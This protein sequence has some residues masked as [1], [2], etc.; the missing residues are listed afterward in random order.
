MFTMAVMLTGRL[1]AESLRVGADLEVADLRVV[2]IGRHDVSN[3]TIPSAGSDPADDSPQGAVAG[4]PP[5]WT[6]LDFEA[7]DDRADDLAQALAAALETENGWWADFVVGGDHVVVFAGRVFRYRIG[8]TRARAEAVAWGEP[9]ELRNIS[10][11]GVTEDS[12]CPVASAALDGSTP[13]QQS[14]M[15]RSSTMRSAGSSPASWTPNLRR[16]VRKPTVHWYPEPPQGSV[17]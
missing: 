6:F 8:D 14:T 5:I 15:T 3:S 13:V 7:P 17:P 2:R 16:V 10:L 1:L 9:Q 4:Q 11:T 12:H